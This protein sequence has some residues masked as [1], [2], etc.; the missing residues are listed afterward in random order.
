VPFYVTADAVSLAFAFF[1]KPRCAKALSLGETGD[2]L[3]TAPGC[4]GLGGG[5]SAEASVV[6]A[7]EAAEQ[8]GAASAP[9]A[10]AAVP[11]E[12]PAGAARSEAGCAEVPTLAALDAAFRAAERFDPAGAAAS[13]AEASAARAAEDALRRAAAAAGDGDG[14]GDGATRQLFVRVTVVAL[15]K[16]PGRKAA[17]RHLTIH[18]L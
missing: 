16:H 11:A 3:V 7:A 5:G 18:N 17:S 12:L 10:A 15:E 4:F 2:F 9:S 13:A 8:T 14:D 1:V 6:D